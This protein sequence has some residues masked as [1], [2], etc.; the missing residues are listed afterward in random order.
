[1]RTIRNKRIFKSSFE[2]GFVLGFAPLI[3]LVLLLNIIVDPYLHHKKRI[4][5]VNHIVTSDNFKDDSAIENL[6]RLNLDESNA[7]V[8]IIGTSHVIKGFPNNSQGNKIE[9]FA[10]PRLAP[11]EAMEIFAKVI[12]QAGIRKSIFIEIS[13]GFI[14]NSR[15]KFS[16]FKRYFNIRTTLSSILMLKNSLRGTDT[17]IFN[18]VPM[19]ELSELDEMRNGLQN[20]LSLAPKQLDSLLAK[21]VFKNSK[22]QHQIVFFTSPLPKGLLEVFGLEQQVQLMNR[23]IMQVVEKA[24]LSHQGVRFSYIGFLGSSI[25]NEY[26][27]WTENFNQGWY[28]DDH[29]KPLTGDIMLDSLLQIASKTKEND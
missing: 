10:I 18:D 3:V 7:E 24:N 16:P 23:E 9:K 8:S 19:P 14:P 13:S 1:M 20:Y 25:G 12:N 17:T 15:K 26:L 5:G 11:N 4:L 21:A 28:D 27:P 6:I 22:I 2:I 29:F